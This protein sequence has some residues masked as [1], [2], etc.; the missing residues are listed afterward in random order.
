MKFISWLLLIL[1][2]AYFQSDCCKAGFLERKAEGWHWYEDRKH[3]DREHEDREQEKQKEQENSSERVSN[4]KADLENKLNLA[5]DIPTEENLIAYMELQNR[6]LEKSQ[7]FSDM[8][9]RV[10]YTNPHLDYTTQFP[11]SQS[12]RHIYLDEE[13]KQTKQIIKNLSQE[14]GLVFFFKGD[15]PYCHGF[16][17]VVKRFAQTYG[18][19]VLAVTLDGGTVPEFP[20]PQRDNG[21]AQN[22]GVGAVPAL[23]AVHP[24]TRKVIPLA[25][26][27]V[28]E[29]EIEQRIIT[30]R[31]RHD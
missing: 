19:E 4:L 12:A 11:V 8:W 9:Q 16:A 22:L 21:T 24:A 29:S 30:L 31:D 28:S 2:F 6:L 17:P 25:Y 20:N 27:M 13:R 1:A 7:N 26:G 3:D 5:I 14:Y 18:L 15:C 23:I 10:I